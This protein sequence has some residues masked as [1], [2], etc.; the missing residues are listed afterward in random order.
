MVKAVTRGQALQ[1]ISQVGTLVKWG[2]LD[3]DDLQKKVLEAAPEE[4]AERL[5]TFL[6]FFHEMNLPLSHSFAL[7]KDLG[8]ITIPKRADRRTCLGSFARRHRAKFVQYRDELTDENFPEPSRI[9]KPGDQLRARIFKKVSPGWSSPDELLAFLKLQNAVLV[10]AQGLTYL[11]EQKDKQLPPNR[12][13][14]SLDQEE[15]LWEHEI[16]G[17]MAPYLFQN[18]IAGSFEFKLGAFRMNWRKTHNYC[19]VCFTEVS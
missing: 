9:L 19:L 8:V 3:G 17:P 5:T 15:H 11:W 13:L 4:F 6:Q 10:G 2:E 12:C 1:L 14:F 18:V 16:L 7:V